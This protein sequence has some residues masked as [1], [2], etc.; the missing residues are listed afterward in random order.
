MR[1][2]TIAAA[3]RIANSTPATPAAQGVARR[4]CCR[5]M[6]SRFLP[7]PPS[8]R[9]QR[10]GARA[11]GV[12]REEDG[13]APYRPWAPGRDGALADLAAETGAQLVIANAEPTPYDD[14]AAEVVREPIA[15]ALPRLLGELT[16]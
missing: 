7:G 4:S 3:I 9:H 8:Y 11:T 10:S 1:T 2:R 5:S 14:Q 12:T 6:V 13:D 16:P 15:T